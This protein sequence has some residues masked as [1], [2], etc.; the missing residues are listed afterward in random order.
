MRAT[1]AETVAEEGRRID[2]GCLKAVF[3]TASLGR[4][5]SSVKGDLISFIMYSYISLSSRVPCTWPSLSGCSPLGAHST[6]SCLSLSDSRG[7]KT[8]SSGKRIGDSNLMTSVTS[9]FDGE[10]VVGLRGGVSCVRSIVSGSCFTRTSST[11]R[12]WKKMR[13][14]ACPGREMRYL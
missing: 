10:L 6:P 1:G 7:A 5:S 3:T 9:V 11:S 2:G 14:T 12:F 4:R 8:E 13:A